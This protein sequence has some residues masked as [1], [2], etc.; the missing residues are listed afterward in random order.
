M[1]STELLV[2]SLVGFFPQLFCVID[3]E[4]S[5]GLMS[6]A[7][8]LMMLSRLLI[9]SGLEHAVQIVGVDLCFLMLRPRWSMVLQGSYIMN[10]PGIL[11]R[12][13]PVHIKWWKTF[14]GSIFGMKPS[15]PALKGP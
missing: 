1:R 8:E 3:L 6:A 9:M 2:R 10:A 12:T 11:S 15:I 13:P 7:G 5:N 4:P 14:K